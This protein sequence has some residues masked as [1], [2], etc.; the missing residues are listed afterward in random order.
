MAHFFISTSGG[1]QSIPHY[2]FALARE[3]AHRGHQVTLLV[4][5][6]ARASEEPAR[7]VAIL[8]W[9]SVRP[10]SWRD[11]LFLS[12]LLRRHRPDCIIGNFA[13]VNLCLL[14]GWLHGTRVRVAWY[15]TM[16][17][18]I[19]ADDSVPQ[20]KW[21]WLKWRKRWVY[22]LATQIIANSRAAAADIQQVFGV[23][24]AKCAVLPPLIPTPELVNR[25]RQPNKIVCVGRVTTAK[26]TATLIRALPLIRQVCPDTFAKL[27]GDGPARKDC[28]AL[29]ASLGVSEA[30]QFTGTLPLP[31]VL[32][33]MAS[34]AVCVSPSE[35]EA[36][37]LVNAEAQAVG[38]P[39]VA[40]AVDGICEVVLDGETGYLV[41][42][43]NHA[44]LAEK[45]VALLTQRELQERLGQRARQHFVENFSHRNI[46]RHAELFERLVNDAKQ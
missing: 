34:A 46:G 43:R 27:I 11:A 38:T 13:A 29:A 44:A 40:S 23:V 19:E 22:R 4:S 25:V 30:C 32:Q 10:T 42:P 28:E 24:P 3:L 2:F 18:A 14:L 26:G 35:S 39:V 41:P 16:R 36:F 12:R 37:G 9:P 6:Q 20:W 8:T 1:N 7:D 5:G 45:I 17:Q 31:E 15:H 33:E 21:V